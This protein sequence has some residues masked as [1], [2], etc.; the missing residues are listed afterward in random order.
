MYAVDRG[1]EDLGKNA[2]CKQCRQL[3]RFSSEL[4]ESWSFDPC[5]SAISASSARCMVG[6]ERFEIN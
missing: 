6:V 1:R 2:L 5:V 3:K 4:E